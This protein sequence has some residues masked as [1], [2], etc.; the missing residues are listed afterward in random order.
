MMCRGYNYSGQSDQPVLV[1][2]AWFSHITPRSSLSHDLVS[3]ILHT[4]QCPSPT[5]SPFQLQQLAQRGAAVGSPCTPMPREAKHQ[6]PAFA[7]GPC[8]QAARQQAQEQADDDDDWEESLTSLSTLLQLPNS[9]LRTH[10]EWRK[11][12]LR[13]QAPRRIAAE[14]DARDLQPHKNR[15]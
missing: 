13:A 12:I 6:S 9:L 14:P 11:T 4:I 2:R 10:E 7:T 1:R 8:E 5:V 15:I 3:D